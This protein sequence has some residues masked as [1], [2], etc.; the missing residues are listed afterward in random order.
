MLILRKSAFPRIAEA[1]DRARRRSRTRSTPPSRSARRPRSCW[2]STAS[3]WPRRAVRPRRSSTRAR[4]A[5]EAHE[6]EAQ[7]EAAEAARAADG[8]DPARHRGRDPPGDPRDPQRG[9]RPDG[10][11]DREGDAQDATDEDQRRLVEDALSRA[12]L[13]RA[14]RH[15]GR[16]TDAGQAPD[17]RDRRGLRAG[18]VR[19]RRG[20]GRSSTRSATSSAQFADALHENRDLAVFFFSPYFSA[21]EKKDGLRPR[22]RSAPSRRS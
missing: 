4:Q 1:L 6:R 2:P 14:Q 11:G 3:G 16:R 8:A 10:A 19:G 5:A 20:A 7:A 15:G 21:E 17:G 13:Q 22:G 12:R 18:A 9:R